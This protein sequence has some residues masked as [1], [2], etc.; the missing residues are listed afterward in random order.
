MAG[1]A[2]SARRHGY[3]VRAPCVLLS[4]GETT[5]TVQGQGRGGRNAEFLLSLSL[6]LKGE[7]TV[8]AIV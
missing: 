7:A 5:V 6:A 3:P 2:Q 1:I 4:G 8:S